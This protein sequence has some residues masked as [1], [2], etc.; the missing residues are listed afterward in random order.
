MKEGFGNGA[1][2]ITLV[3]VPFIWIQIMLGVWVCGQS[4]LLW[5]TRDPM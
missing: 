1:T 5:R 2:L 3:L 4:E